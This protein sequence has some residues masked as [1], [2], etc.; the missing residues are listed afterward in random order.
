MRD[1][2]WVLLCSAVA[3]G[4]CKEQDQSVQWSEIEGIPD[5]FKDGRDDTRLDEE[6]RAIAYDE[7]S[8]VAMALQ[9]QFVSAEADPVYAASAAAAIS[10]EN[11][12]AWN[13]LTAAG[14]HRSAGYLTAESDPQF[15][16]SAASTV[17][18]TDITHWDTAYGWGSHANA[19]YL[20]TES[21]PKIGSLTAGA[22]PA[23]SGSALV[24]GSIHDVGGNVGIGTSTPSALLTVSTVAKIG[25]TY[26]TSTSKTCS[27]SGNSWTNTSS[28]RAACDSYCTSLGQ[29]FTGGSVSGTGVKPAGGATC[30]YISDF[31][32]CT[33][34]SIPNTGC[35]SRALDFVCTCLAVGNEFTGGVRMMGGNVGIGVSSPN[36]PLQ[37]GGYLQL[38]TTAGPP[39]A[40][41]CDAATER[42][43]MLVDPATGSLWVC[44]D[45]GWISK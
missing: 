40:E 31:N 38:D 16:A 25:E 14:D 24:S 21:D 9:G 43:R 19:G 27:I 34:S 13:A 42:G 37:V 12:T 29:G 32:T 35:D 11:V 26:A 39:P 45:S 33:K 28:S 41:D 5:G 6:I 22:V 2:K 3:L 23:W 20:T 1:L 18:T 8:E 10:Q 17:S 30:D 4:A 36:S 7:P 15:A 44:A